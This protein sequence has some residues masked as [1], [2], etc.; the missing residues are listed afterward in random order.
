MWN[1]W[2]WGVHYSLQSCENGLL[3]FS[4]LS[5]FS[6]QLL[7]AAPRY[8]GKGCSGFKEGI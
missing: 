8:L 7:I 3:L 2:G 1:V 4:M 5:R 6:P